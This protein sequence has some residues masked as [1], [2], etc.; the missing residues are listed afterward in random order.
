MERHRTFIEKE[1]LAGSD[2]ERLELFANFMVHESRLRRDRYHTA[3]NAMAGDIVDLTRDMWRSYTRT[4]KRAAT[5]STSMSSF[6]HTVPSWASDGQRSAHGGMPSSASSF[7]DFTPATDVGSVGEEG[8]ERSESRQWTETFKPSLS[9]IQ[10]VAQSTL[11]DEDSSRGRA[12]SR[13][14]ENKSSGS[15]SI[16]KP[17][18]IE[19]SHRETKYMG[20]RASQ[21]RE[22]A[23]PSPALS[24][25]TA[26]PGASTQTFGE[27]AGEYPP[28][29]VGWHEGG[30]FDTPMATPAHIRERK[31]ST[32]GVEPLDVSRLVTLPP[33]YPRHHPAVNN[34]HPI[35]NDLRSEHRKLA[36][37]SDIQQIKDAFLDQDFAAQQMQKEAAKER[38]SRLRSSIQGKV[39]S[40]TISFAEA[41]QAE[42]DFNVEEAERGKANARALFDMFETS[43]AQP[44]N[45]LLTDRIGEANAAIGQ[46][47]TELSF[48]NQ[49]SDPNQAQEE[50]DE[51]PE[52]LEKLTLLKWLF[53]AREQLHKEMFD[54]HAMR[55][56][57][58]SEVIL[59]P[60]R[61]QR[62]Q[63]KIDEAT[64][65]F[66]KDSNERQT[67]FAK[68]SLKRFE[69]LQQ[70]M[71]KNVSRGVEDQLS[72]FWD[73]APNLMEVITRV[74]AQMAG[75]E[76]Q[77]PAQEYDENPSYQEYPL[78]YLYS[79]LSHAE[80]S[81]YQFIES[82]TNLLCLLHEV[83]TAA[84][85]SGL[86][87]V[88]IQRLAAS[89]NDADLRAELL[90]ARR[91]AEETLTQDLKEKVGQVEE[92]WKEALGD[93][94]EECKERVKKWLE[95]SGGWEDG[96]D[97]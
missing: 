68:D 16:G 3:Y 33:P 45:V 5:P 49:A 50:G 6:D 66:T 67:A 34:S 80:K 43:V 77:I 17:D 71:E 39:A 7:G 58:Y 28:E 11:R 62:A 78:Q 23:E 73:I 51:Q 89:P 8:F 61:I 42:A 9:P 53:E 12:P 54:L 91:E 38:R 44:L 97:G 74:P 88:E 95:E 37:H 69:E 35:L 87:L 32:P 18:R 10:S 94:L 4:S 19:K 96:L 56:E 30:D 65:F 90:Q 41:A 2:E 60:Y 15:G 84:S 29:K 20:I 14:W 36:D 48:G 1:A 21:L 70:V 47:R 75:F 31:T 27:S 92:Q 25:H 83:R 64:A 72:A 57:K 79:L 26:T 59:T 13:W 85:K 55:S 63:A 22:D 86:R 76:V 93:G 81:A 82:Q 46:L 52:R 40:G 24:R